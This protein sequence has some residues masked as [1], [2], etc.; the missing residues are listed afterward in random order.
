MAFRSELPIRAIPVEHLRRADW[1]P[2]TIRRDRLD[3]LKESIRDDPSFMWRR[4]ILAM[5]DGT[6]YAG[7]M[8]LQA[9]VE[10]GWTTVPALLEDVP[11]S[12]ARQ[13]ALRDNNSWG[14]WDDA[15]L[16]VFLRNLDA[17]VDVGN[18]GFTDRE[19]AAIMAEAKQEGHQAPQQRRTDDEPTLLE[20]KTYGTVTRTTDYGR[21]VFADNFIRQIVLYF[22]GQDYV[23]MV[24]MLTMLREHFG[25]DNNTE[26]VGRIV[27]E[28][29]A[30]HCSPVA[31]D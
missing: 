20:D 12:L 16:T 22:A 7:N 17:D 11:E 1:N 21:G 28:Y 15:A 13:R 24:D 9:C 27:R 5:Q 29:H 4:P 8:R 23:E 14:E 18:V 6:V 25:V 19:L 30:T 10:L 2:K 31:T 26:V 3:S